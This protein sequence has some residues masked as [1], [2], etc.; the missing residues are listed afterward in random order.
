MGAAI[1]CV[2]SDDRPGVETCLATA[3]AAHSIDILGAH[4]YSRAARRGAEVVHFLWLRRDEAIAPTLVEQDVYRFSNLFGGLVTGELRVDGRPPVQRHLPSPEAAVIVRFDAS[5]DLH[6]PAFFSL[7]T[8]A[9][10]GLLRAV[11]LA[12]VR[13]N[14]HVVGQSRIQGPGA[15]E[16]FR[17]AV[18]EPDG[19]A[20]DQ[21]R[22]GA[23]QAEILRLV[24]PIDR[25]TVLTTEHVSGEYAI[26]F[27]R[28]GESAPPEADEAEEP[29]SA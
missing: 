2:V 21:Y 9:R 12:L 28:F 20:P 1:V 14:A 16:T 6:K 26:P 19:R 4:V 25:R 3:L 8:R 22:R 17:F 7:E 10:P 11:H 29:L 27:G 24:E 5:D 23:M 18:L 15:R 13:M